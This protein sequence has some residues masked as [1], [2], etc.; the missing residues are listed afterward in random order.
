ME[1]KT[2]TRDYERIGRFIYAFARFA[3]PDVLRALPAS[4]SLAPDLAARGAALARRFDD[5]METF[6]RDARE[7]RSDTLDDEALRAI[8]A[9]L[10]TFVK[11]SG[12]KRW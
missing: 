11:D 9:D 7:G 8:L 4:G 2:A 6:G 1:Q 5:A 3:N 12:S 10:E